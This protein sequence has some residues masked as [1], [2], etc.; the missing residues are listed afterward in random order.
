MMSGGLFAIDKNYFYEMGGY[1]K[2]ME[3]WG[4]ENIEMSLRVSF[5]AVFISASLLLVFRYLQITTM[6]EKKPSPK[7]Y[8]SVKL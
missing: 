2:G 1:D 3:I 5:F 6:K 7:E 8:T 4:G